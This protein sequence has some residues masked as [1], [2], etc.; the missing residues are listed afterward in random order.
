MW[1]ETAASFAG[2]YYHIEN[3]Y[4]APRPDP[5]P[6]LLIGGGGERKTLRVVAQHADWWNYPGGTADNYAHKLEVL[7]QHCQ[8]VER[9]YE[10]I[11]KT[12][13]ALT[14]TH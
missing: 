11:V 7:R 10:E 2:T 14:H 8:T 3:A 9:N 4:C 12:W 13:S 6:P 1:T 5:I